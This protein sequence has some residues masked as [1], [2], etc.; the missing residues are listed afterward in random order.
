MIAPGPSA[1][2]TMKLDPI[3]L[4]L[5]ASTPVRLTVGLL[6]IAGTGV[7]LIAILKLMQIGR[8]RK[9]QRAFEEDS[10]AARIGKDLYDAAML[11]RDSPGG[12]IVL[13]M[14]SRASAAGTERMRA[15]AERAIVEERAR[16]TTLM[17]TLGSI[18][19]ASPF[20]GL[21]G[22]VYGI[23]DAFIRIGQEKSASLPVVA[24]A[25]GEAL[26]ATAIG[27]AAAIPAV[28]FYNAIDKQISD[29]LDQIES[30][31][32]DWALLLLV[33]SPAE[34]GAQPARPTSHF[35]APPSTGAARGH[36]R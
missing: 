32:T 19:A 33:R 4:L 36:G 18:G 26:V 13:L 25:I 23:M 2:V 28:I 34:A 12:R 27:L 35:P 1:A 21:F 9:R 17:A 14:A 22:T 31:V 10:A 3:A 30:S 11:H 24:P 29:L 8:L 15:V 16:A 20:V 6:L 7:W 5:H